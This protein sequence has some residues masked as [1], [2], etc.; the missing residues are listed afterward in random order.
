MKQ[1]DTNAIANLYVESINRGADT[2]KVSDK[3][4]SKICD[5][6]SKL[7]RQGVSLEDAT[8]QIQNTLDSG[9]NT[10]DLVETIKRV[11]EVTN[12]PSIRNRMLGSDT[13]ANHRTSTLP[14]SES[15]RPNYPT[16][17]RI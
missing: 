2:S 9:E 4:Y 6:V 17:R 8:M 1:S 5:M 16:S 7:K 14:R 10:N 12:S 15:G 3:T 13:D 11:W